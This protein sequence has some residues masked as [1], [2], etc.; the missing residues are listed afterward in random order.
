M[1]VSLLGPL[2]EA[3]SL[4]TLEVRRLGGTV[5]SDGTWASVLIYFIYCPRGVSP[6]VDNTYYLACPPLFC[7]YF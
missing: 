3:Y 4:L 1:V 7:T 2:V 6:I 5:L